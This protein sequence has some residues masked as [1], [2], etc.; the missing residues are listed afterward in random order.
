LTIDDCGANKKNILM[1]II[2][3][4]ENYKHENKFV[5]RKGRKEETRGDSQ[6]K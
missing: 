1:A 3:N 6:K 5:S 2:R 4:L